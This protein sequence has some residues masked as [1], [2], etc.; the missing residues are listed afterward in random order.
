M[1]SI[2]KF[3]FLNKKEGIAIM[4]RFDLLK[5]FLFLLF[6]FMSLSVLGMDDPSDL[7]FVSQNRAGFS[8]F[9]MNDKMTEHFRKVYQ[10]EEIFMPGPKSDNY[11]FSVLKGKKL[12]CFAAFV[13]K[14]S[15]FEIDLLKGMPLEV[16]NLSFST[17]RKL[18]ELQPL[19]TSSLKELYLSG[20]ILDEPSL[21][22]PLKLET[23]VLNGLT[24]NDDIMMI[25]AQMKSLKRLEL[26]FH[27]EDKFNEFWI[28]RNDIPFAILNDLTLTALRLD[29]PTPAVLYFLEKQKQLKIL[30]V[31]VAPSFKIS[32]LISSI[33]GREFDLLAIK[34]FNKPDLGE[35][36]D[37]LNKY[38]VKVKV[39]LVDGKRV[40]PENDNEE[41]KSEQKSTK[42]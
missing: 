20:V 26:T 19:L 1:Q 32:N 9:A 41:I 18:S 17:P 13:G 6:S 35:L 22:S 4:K 16:L 36:K 27:Y 14:K 8:R 10:A 38:Q 40:I 21:L 31:A 15:N 29:F 37:L 23:L 24:Y 28:K 30:T 7:Y 33:A 3:A 34:W 2:I 12:K 42:I 39:L 11:D 25:I 5:C